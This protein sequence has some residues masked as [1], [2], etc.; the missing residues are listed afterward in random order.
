MS[1]I[2]V[3][4]QDQRCLEQL[5]VGLAAEGYHVITCVDRPHELELAFQSAP[6]LVI[7]DCAPPL[8]SGLHLCRRL[9]TL[10]GAPLFILTATTNDDFIV[11]C[12]EAGAV[13][14]AVKPYSHPVLMAKIRAVL[15]RIAPDPFA[16][17]SY[18]DDYLT[19]DLKKGKLLVA[20]RVIQLSPTEFRLLAYLFRNSD[21]V[22]P[23]KELIE[24]VWQTPTRSTRRLLKLYIFYL[25]RKIEKDPRSPAYLQSIWGVGYRFWR[26]V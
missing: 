20:G 19:L 13:D 12:L 3:I 9:V 7:Q 26:K 15:R 22:V 17:I 18:Q 4:G 5:E 25:R 1:R 11:K 24:A 23:H 2:L 21:R 8:Q 6:D 16:E 14:Y 10:T